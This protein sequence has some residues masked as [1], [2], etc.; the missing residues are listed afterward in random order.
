MREL[1]VQAVRAPGPADPRRIHPGSCVRSPAFFW[2]LAATPSFNERRAVLRLTPSGN[3][4]SRVVLRDVA[5]NC[6][7]GESFRE[8]EKYLSVQANEG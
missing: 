1:G 6:L 7:P 4:V 5:G 8:K 2:V 3:K